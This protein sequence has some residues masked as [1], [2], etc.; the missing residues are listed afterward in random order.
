MARAAAV[1]PVSLLLLPGA[2]AIASETYT[3]NAIC[4]PNYCTNPLFPGLNDLPR[5]EQIVWQCPQPGHSAQ[6]YMN[7][8]AN[9]VLYD[10]A[11]P[12]P[13][14]TAATMGSLIKSQD[15][16]AATM[17]FYHM[18]ALGYEAWDYQNPSQSKDE[19]IRAAWKLTCYT[20][21]P[22]AQLACAANQASPYMRPC[23]N[24]CSDYLQACRVECCDE[25]PQCL[26]THSVEIPGGSSFIQ[27][28]YFD[29]LGP[30]P[31]CTGMY[32]SGGRAAPLLALLVALF[33]LHAAAA[34]AGAGAGPATTAAPRTGRG[35]WSLPI[36]LWEV[37]FFAVL[38][39]TFQGC[40]LDVPRHQLG[41]WRGNQDYLVQYQYVPPNGQT[42]RLNSCGIEG[43][44]ETLQCNGR[45]YCRSWMGAG[46]TNSI[47]FCFCERDW[48]DPECSTPRKSQSKAFLLTLFGGFFGLEYFYLGLPGVA[49]SK[50]CTLGGFGVWWLYDIVRI[51]SGPVYASDFRV[52]PDLPFWGYVLTVLF[53]FVIGGFAVSLVSILRYRNKKRKDVMLLLQAEEGGEMDAADMAGL[54]PQYGSVGPDFKGTRA[55]SGYGSTLGMSLPNAGA[56]FAQMSQQPGPFAGPYG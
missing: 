23:K 26:F 22:K 53:I 36:G 40:D 14:A 30:A 12:S 15:D 49:T 10:P 32:S 20:Y 50:L 55:F 46:V 5:L 6:T 37:A 18:N 4:R 33:G 1:V 35:S 28:G 25:S 54:G 41:N 13:N 38:A 45:G 48:A 44:P 39:L 2:A 27:T 52:A 56:P 47:S 21:F 3:Q 42:S 16:A 7:F 9:A 8:C 43:L 17:Y 31:Q 19:C 11:M 24:G 51:G 34:G 29:A